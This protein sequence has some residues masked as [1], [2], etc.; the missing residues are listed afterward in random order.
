MPGTCAAKM[1]RG[2]IGLKR[3]AH[4]TC[5]S[6]LMSGQV[7]D[8]KLGNTTLTVRCQVGAWDTSVS[9]GNGAVGAVRGLASKPCIPAKRSEAVEFKLAESLR[10]ARDR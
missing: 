1:Q 10:K 4:A 6:R 5:C 9:R 2:S 8:I 7:Q 3:F